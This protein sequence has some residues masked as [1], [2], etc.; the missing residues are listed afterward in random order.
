[1]PATP[2]PPA[3]PALD[4][5]EH[6]FGAL[7]GLRMHVVEAGSGEPVLL[8]HGCPQHWWE[9]RKVIPGLAKHYRVIVPDLRGAGWTDAPRAGYTHAQ[10]LADLI[11][12][13]DA[14]ELEQVR[15]IAHDWAAIVGFAL[16]LE[17]PERVERYISVSL[18]HPYLRFDPRLLASFRHL[19][20][21]PVIAIP[22]LGPLA[23]GRGNQPVTHY[24]FSHYTHPAAFS[25]EDL[26]LF[27]APL[28]NPARARA[29]SALYR[30]LI[31]PEFVRIL[32]G[33]YRDTRL[34]TPTLS[35][36]GTDDPAV[37]PDLLSSA[38]DDADDLRVV[39]VDGASHFLVDEK[40]KVVVSRAMAFFA[41]GPSTV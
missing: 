18:P 7:P 38:E 3:L 36:V 22:G 27:L 29:G 30:R 4:G 28:R 16:C 41:P 9:W 34:R 25:P 33:A 11:G 21:Q 1:M 15:V 37:R 23:L 39:F 8:L 13:L 31:L 24:L 40:P 19:W 14:L 10:L 35:L 12:L 26:E 20:F 5:V 17:Y 6:H 32:S 2:W